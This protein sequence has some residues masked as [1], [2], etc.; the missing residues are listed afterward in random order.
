MTEYSKEIE[1]VKN[2]KNISEALYASS[3]YTLKK[4]F[5]NDQ[6]VLRLVKAGREVTPLLV[7]ELAKN[8]LELN[9]ITLSCFAYILHKVDPK[10]AVKILKPLFVKAMENPGAFFVYFAA[11]A[12]RQESNLPTKPLELDYTRAEL[13][14]TLK[15]I[16]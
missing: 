3:P 10:L 2:P 16:S 12:L 11:H 7:E 8:G 1:K 15:K 9:E 4:A 6:T 5:E 13:R 14:E